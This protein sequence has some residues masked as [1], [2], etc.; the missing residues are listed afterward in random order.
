MLIV[1]H[2]RP[3]FTHA[4]QRD[5]EDTVH[6]SLLRIL[7]PHGFY[8]RANVEGST[9]R[10]AVEAFGIEKLCGKATL[11]YARCKIIYLCPPLFPCR[12]SVFVYLALLVHV[13][14]GVGL[15]TSSALL[16][17]ESRCARFF[18]V[19]FAL[20]LLLFS[21]ALLVHVRG[22][23]V[24]IETAGALLGCESRRGRFFFLGLALSLFCF[25]WLSLCTCAAWA[26]V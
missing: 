3:E 9:P 16:R 6:S 14:V 18:F 12:C 4:V 26:C 5:L 21:L 24:R 20:A 10:K 2:R 17:C 7:P 1:A 11:S 8:I 19:G 15:A 13:R 23:G 25:L 22:V